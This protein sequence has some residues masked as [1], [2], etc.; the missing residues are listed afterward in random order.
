M[1]NGSSSVLKLV[2]IV[3][4]IGKKIRNPSTQARTVTNILR[5]Y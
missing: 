5:C 1:A 4:R 2:R 3:H